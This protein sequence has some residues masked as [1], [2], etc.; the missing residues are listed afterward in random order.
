MTKGKPWPTDDERKLKDWFSSGT[1]ELRVL[2]FS[3]DGQYSENA[4]YQKLLDLGLLSKEEET[5]KN[6]TSSST[7]LELPPE[8]PN[9]ETSLKTLCAALKALETPGLDKAEVLRLR[10]I[11]SGVKIYKEL[12]AD[13]L[14]YRGL[15]ERLIE[16]EGKYASLV[17]KS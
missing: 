7:S 10:G 16:L 11:I 1:T 14:D 8:L 9:I 15:E 2:S 3:F 17:K 4:I 13:Y 5:R 6:R 12:F